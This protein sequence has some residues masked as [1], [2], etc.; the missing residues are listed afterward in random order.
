MSAVAVECWPKFARSF[1]MLL[2]SRPLLKRKICRFQNY[3]AFFRQHYL[4]CLVCLGE[5]A[6]KSEGE[7]HADRRHRSTLRRHSRSSIVARRV[8]GKLPFAVRTSEQAA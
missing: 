2:S 5:V 1:Q 6:A 7:C 4:A 8:Q 3:L